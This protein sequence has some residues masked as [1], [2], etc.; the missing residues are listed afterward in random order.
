MAHQIP[1][2]KLKWLREFYIYNLFDTIE[3]SRIRDYLIVFLAGLYPYQHSCRL[4]ADTHLY[5]GVNQA[6][7][8]YGKDEKVFSLSLSDLNVRMQQAAKQRVLLYH[9]RWLNAWGT[10]NFLRQVCEWSMIFVAFDSA[11]LSFLWPAF[12]NQK[13]LNFSV[14][15]EI[16][17]NNWRTRSY[18]TGSFL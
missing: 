3:L 2:K 6:N 1:N 9:L 14:Q 4:Q 13:A 12:R 15:R 16:I 11:W 18:F 8:G 17:D 10:L 5:R 7:L